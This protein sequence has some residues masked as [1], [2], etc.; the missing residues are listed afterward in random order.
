M[1]CRIVSTFIF[2]GALAAGPAGQDPQQPLKSGVELVMVDAQVVDKKG[3]PIAGLT[4]QN[5]QVSIGGKRRTVVSAELLDANTGLPRGAT[6]GSAPRSMPGNIYILAVDQGSFRP[7]NA[8]SVIHAA[9]EFL[10]RARPNDYVGMVSFPA[11]GVII[12]PTR[13]RAE[14]EAAI[15]KLVG[16]SQLKQ[17]RQYQYS[18][19]D[20]IDIG[21][22]GMNRDNDVLQRVVQRNCPPNDMMCPRALENE[23]AETISLL[24]MQSA[25]SLAGIRSVIGG[26]KG[27]PGRKTLVVM[28]AGVPSGD[29][30]GA[31]L[32]MKADAT[33]AGKEAAAA[34]ILLYTL[35]LNTAFLDSFSPDAPSAQQTAMREA[36]VYALGLDTFNGHAGGTFLEVN[37]GADFAVDRMMRETAAYYLLGVQVEDADRNGEAHRIE[38]KVNQ[39]GANVRNR[40]S[41]VIPKKGS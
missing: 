12:N 34:G 18:L 28:S 19:S 8:P 41:V 27:I 39:R 2:A 24:E 31:R 5:F 3:D 15:P 22:A 35:H 20:A 37:T 40:A 10:K 23:V 30:T 14:L 16:F 33:Q 21:S 13:D 7:V 29:R 36:G 25:R 26:I 4:T 1:F 6:D 38:V 9:R 32:Y 17:Q 11:P